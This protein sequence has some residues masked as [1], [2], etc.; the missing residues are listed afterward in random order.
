M[1]SPPRTPR[2]PSRVLPER[3]PP[4]ISYPEDLPV[5]AKRAEIAR[6]LQAHQ[7]IIVCGETGSGK[8]TQLPKICLELGRGLKGMIGHTQPRRLAARSVSQRIAEELGEL[9]NV[10][11]SRGTCLEI[12]WPGTFPIHVDAEIRPPVG[13]RPR[14]RNP[15]AGAMGVSSATEENLVRVEVMPQA[16][17]IWKPAPPESKE[18]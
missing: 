9:P 16:L 6:A 2:Q 18:E 13:E 17:E 1:H 5:S 11:V 4:S 10:E 8:T 14:D 12:H 3:L 15:A 7:V